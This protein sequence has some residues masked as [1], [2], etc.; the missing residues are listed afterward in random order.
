[1][2]QRFGAR[3]LD[4]L[5]IGVPFAIIYGVLVIGAA[6]SSSAGSAGSTG[7]ASGMA[8][9]FQ[10]AFSV[11]VVLYEMG[12]VATRGATLGKQIL[13]VKVV[14]EADGQIPGWGPSA[15]RWVIPFVGS[16]ACGIG[17]LV[18]YLSPFWD[19]TGRQQGWH[20]KVAHTLVIRTK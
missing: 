16:F 14:R 18:V 11:G 1:M 17:Q 19:N 20:D 7:A 4:A 5:I 9:L 10:V 6:T 13:G 12:M 15:L 8:V 3:L 2:G